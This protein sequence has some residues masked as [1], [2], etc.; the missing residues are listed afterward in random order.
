MRIG[1]VPM[2]EFILKDL[3]KGENLHAEISSCSREKERNNEN[4][5]QTG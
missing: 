1:W 5:R 4:M 3:Y 2:K